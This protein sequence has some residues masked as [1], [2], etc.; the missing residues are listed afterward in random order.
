M[1]MAA[2]ADAVRKLNTPAA[3]QQARTLRAP[4]D[5]RDARLDAVE[6]LP[7]LA[8]DDLEL[9]VGGLAAGDLFILLPRGG[10]K[11]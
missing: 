1:M 9:A 5:L 10:G 8:R 2:A 6:Q 3:G 7:V 11:G 4:C